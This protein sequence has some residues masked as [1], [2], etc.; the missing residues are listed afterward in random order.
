MQGR[1]LSTQVTQ[2]MKEMIMIT[3]VLN[4]LVE[5]KHGASLKIPIRFS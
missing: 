4:D 5:I 1:V 3:E 2:V